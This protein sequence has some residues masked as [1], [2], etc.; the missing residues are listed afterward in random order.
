MEPT[1]NTSLVDLIQNDPEVIT[2][3][4]AKSS[5][6]KS[7]R[8]VNLTTILA[9]LSEFTPEEIMSYPINTII[10]IKT[11]G[12]RISSVYAKGVEELNNSDG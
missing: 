5:K 3:A 7:S 10:G 12:N 2:V 6:T 8:Q 4:E 9:Q 1:D 11:Q